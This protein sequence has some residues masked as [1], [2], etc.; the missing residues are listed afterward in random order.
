MRYFHTARPVCASWC[1]LD[2][3]KASSMGRLMKFV[4]AMIIALS[5][6]ASP[7]AARTPPSVSCTVSGAAQGMAADHD[8]MACCTPDCATPCPPALLPV[9]AFG[10]EP[11]EPLVSFE[12]RPPVGS[13]RSIKPSMVDPPPRPFL[14]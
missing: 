6:A 13:F 4:W 10:H 9:A 3:G 2:R 8:K 1:E 7:S 11:V 12:W 14:A 5:L